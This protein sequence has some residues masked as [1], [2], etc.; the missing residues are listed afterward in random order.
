MVK[1]E[2]KHTHTW[3]EN[4][5]DRGSSKDRAPLMG[6]GL[7]YWGNLRD[8]S[9]TTA[10]WEK[11]RRLREE[12]NSYRGQEQGKFVKPEAEAVRKP[13]ES[14]MHLSKS[15][16]HYL[17]SLYVLGSWCWTF[18][19]N[20]DFCLWSGKVGEDRRETQPQRTQGRIQGDFFLLALSVMKNNN[21]KPPTCLSW[22]VLSLLS[23]SS[24]LFA[25]ML[26]SCV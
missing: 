8:A 13:L 9:V 17:F 3:R 12:V 1:N 23:F 6:L 4:I 22:D 10:V 21:K 16:G 5:Q 14:T 24:G 25:T 11:E 26:H 19:N 2:A 18:N 7:A 15:W 20:Q